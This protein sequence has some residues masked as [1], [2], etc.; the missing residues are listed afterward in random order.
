MSSF[1]KKLRNLLPRIIIV[2]MLL[3]LLWWALLLFQKNSDLTSERIKLL[4][5]ESNIEYKVNNYDIKTLEAYDEIISKHKRQQLMIIGE[6][7][8]FGLSLIIGMA[9]IN[10][11]HFKEIANNIQQKNFLLSITHE[12]KSPLAS[13]GL[14][15]ETLKKRALKVEQ[16]HALAESG[17]NENRRL[18]KQIN[19]L[20]FATR[21]EE[22]YQFNF[23]LIDINEVLSELAQRY[24]KLHQENLVKYNSDISS[25]SILADKESIQSLFINLIDNSIKYNNQKPII[26]IS[27]SGQDQLVQIEVTDNG[28]GIPENEISNVMKKFYRI[29]SEETRNTKGTGLGLYIVNKI[30][31]AHSGKI[32]IKSSKSN[33]TSI[34]ITLPKNQ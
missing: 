26:S 33:G 30:V 25:P 23:E 10:R 6:G 3:G 16:I 2:Y 34:T 17:M 13:I 29:G 14:I 1:N 24:N 8:V 22:A 28:I 5:L 19:N 11:A 12:L 21:L 27:A 4:Q 20:L 15:F 18:E 7:L 32:R 9:L 31:D